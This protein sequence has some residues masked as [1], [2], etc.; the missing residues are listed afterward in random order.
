[1][2]KPGWFWDGQ[3]QKMRKKADKWLKSATGGNWNRMMFWT[4]VERQ[5][6]PSVSYGLC[7]SIASLKELDGALKNQYYKIAPKGR[8][9]QI[10]R[11]RSGNWGEA[12]IE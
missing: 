2:H 4:S 3:Y 6:W 11:E 5:F 9:R 12:S 8:L 7:C 1:M 10:A